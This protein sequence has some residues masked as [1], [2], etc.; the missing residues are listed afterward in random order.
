MPDSLDLGSTPGQPFP[1]VPFCVCL[2]GPAAASWSPLEFLSSFPTP[3]G[4]M[5]L[6]L[7]VRLGFCSGPAE[8][9]S[10]A[11]L[12]LLP[13]EFSRASPLCWLSLGSYRPCDCLLFAWNSYCT[14][15]FLLE[16]SPVR[17]SW[18]HSG[19]WRRRSAHRLCKS[20][21]WG[22]LCEHLDETRVTAKLSKL[23]I[24]CISQLPS[25]Y[26]SF[27]SLSLKPWCST[28]STHF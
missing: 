15:L 19:A 13:L 12:R 28:L 10:R 11:F 8:H 17:V 18:K 25:W 1:A 6:R 23:Y 3:S 26:F 4:L 16:Q 27:F 2:W 14:L 24:V 7:W 5:Q 20:H 22:C 9:L 21:L